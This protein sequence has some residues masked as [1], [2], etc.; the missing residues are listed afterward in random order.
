[1]QNR[2]VFAMTEHESRMH[3]IIHRTLHDIDMRALLLHMS[4]VSCDSRCR[5][6]KCMPCIRT[7]DALHVNPFVY[8][9]AQ[10][11]RPKL[12]LY[13]CISN[14]VPTS[15]KKRKSRLCNISIPMSN[16]IQIT[17]W[18]LNYAALINVI[19]QDTQHK[20]HIYFCH[21]YL[22][23]VPFSLLSYLDPCHLRQPFRSIY[24]TTH[25]PY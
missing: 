3:D 24:C 8:T 9:S 20:I 10:Q 17:F 19:V 25:N 13:I 2:L 14:V 11:I 18:M 4:V 7:M 15:A 6:F 12:T 5:V 23:Q 1:M 16:S 21:A 22:S